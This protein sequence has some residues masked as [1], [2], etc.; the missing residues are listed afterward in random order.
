MGGVEVWT[1]RAER[2]GEGTLRLAYG[3]PLERDAAP[4]QTFSVPVTIR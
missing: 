1:F 4:A 3:R 2:A